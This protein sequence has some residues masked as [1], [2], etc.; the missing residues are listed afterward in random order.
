MAKRDNRAHRGTIAVR[1]SGTGTTTRR[2][3][4]NEPA[5]RAVCALFVLLEH[6]EIVFTNENAV[7]HRSM[8]RNELRVIDVDAIHKNGSRSLRFENFF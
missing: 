5:S 1:N 2:A 7:L 4:G 8:S 3:N 6:I